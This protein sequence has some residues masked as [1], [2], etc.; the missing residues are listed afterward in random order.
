MWPPT[1]RFVIDHADP[2]LDC[3]REVV[4]VAPRQV[5][6][7]REGFTDSAWD[8]QGPVA[9]S[10]YTW[11]LWTKGLARRALRVRRARGARFRSHGPPYY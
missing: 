1:G 10:V 11:S 8:A 2:A 4:A 7:R 6:V 5:L 3:R 9:E